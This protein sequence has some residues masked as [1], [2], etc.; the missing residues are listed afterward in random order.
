MSTPREQLIKSLHSALFPIND[1]HRIRYVLSKTGPFFLLRVYN[2]LSTSVEWKEVALVWLCS[3]ALYGNKVVRMAARN[4]LMYD[5]DQLIDADTYAN[6]ECL[7]NSI[8]DRVMTPENKVL[9]TM[10]KA[11]GNVVFCMN[12]P[13]DFEKSVFQLK[14]YFMMYYL[15]ERFTADKS[16]EFL[17]TY[18][19]S[20]LGMIGIN[21]EFVPHITYM[22][23][24]L[25]AKKVM[26]ERKLQYGLLQEIHDHYCEVTGVSQ[27]HPK[28]AML[29]RCVDRVVAC[30]K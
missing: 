10:L 19:L 17:V 4:A 11:L 14:G 9:L 1:V 28:V 6:I 21:K 22:L 23:G 20:L 27:Q 5:C 30:L 24:V 15:P 2:D 25:C 12:D 29:E 26:V 18:A 7:R 8:C 3:L 16:V 13:R